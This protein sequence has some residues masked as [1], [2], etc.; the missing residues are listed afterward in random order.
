MFEI[1][2]L[3]RDA[4]PLVLLK[5]N[6]GY[7]RTEDARAFGGDYMIAKLFGAQEMLQ[8]T[9]NCCSVSSTAAVCCGTHASTARLGQ[10]DLTGLACQCRLVGDRQLIS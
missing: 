5:P 1:G 6:W 2:L 10:L 8:I 7:R 9:V 3:H 4:P